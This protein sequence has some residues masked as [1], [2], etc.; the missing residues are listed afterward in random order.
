MHGLTWL[1]AG[2]VLL[3]AS[4]GASDARSHPV[5]VE[6]ASGVVADLHRPPAASSATTPVAVL[7]HG[8]CGD[9]R[10]MAEL[11]RALARSGTVV[12][13]PDVRAFRRGGGWPGTYRDVVCAVAAGRALAADQ[14]VGTPVVLIGWG[15][16]AFVASAV[17]LGWSTLAAAV[18]GCTAPVPARGPDVLVGLSGHYGWAPDAAAPVDAAT[19]AWFGGPPASDPTAWSHGNPRWWVRRVSPADVPPTVLLAAT[20]HPE[21]AA[22]ADDL[23]AAGVPVELFDCGPGTH[24]ALVHPR[25]VSGALALGS[26][27]RVLGTGSER[28]GCS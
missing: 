22:F 27:L 15:D 25:G 10:D 8:C 21:S 14:G 20:A 7:V 18:S 4:T 24:E 3:S 12:L 6:F 1:L 19:R 28:P 9:R 16:G 13:N 26:L 2:A 5:T 17:T 11:S 23:R